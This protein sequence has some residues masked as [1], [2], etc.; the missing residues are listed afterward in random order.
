M[1]GIETLA[2]SIALLAAGGLLLSA[3]GE[4]KATDESTAEGATANARLAAEVVASEELILEL[5]PTLKK[6]APELFSEQCEFTG[7]SPETNSEVTFE[8]LAVEERIWS[9]PRRRAL[10]RPP[11]LGDLLTPPGLET[12]EIGK[13][14]IS[15][16]KGRF[17]S[18]GRTRFESV[19]GISSRHSGMARLS[20]NIAQWSRDPGTGRWQIMDWKQKSL[21]ALRAPAPFFE[22]V[23][24]R[25][26]PDAKT[27]AAARTSLHQKILVENYFGGNPARNRPGYSDSRFYPDSVNIHPALSVADVDGDG[28]EDLYVCVRW[29]K[30]L[31]LRNRGDGTFEEC[32]TRFGLDVDGRNTVALF[33]DFDNDGD[34]DLLLG[35]SLERSL[36]L[37][38]RE[39]RFAP[40]PDPVVNGALPWLVTS[41]SAADV[42]ND[43][44]LDVYLCTY[45]PLD[46]NQRISGQAV[47]SA[48]EWARRFLASEDE[49][50]VVRRQTE[51]HSYLAQV[52]PPNV[53]L[54]GRGTHFEVAPS[55]PGM[56]G[57][58][59]SFHAAWNDYDRDGDQ[60]LYVA[61]DFAPDFFYRNDGSGGFTDITAA[62][63]IDTMGFAMGAAWGDYD[64]DGYDD[65]YVSNMYS[66]AGRRITAQIPGL[67]RRFAATAGG[68]FLYRNQGDGTLERM[69]GGDGK[70]IPVHL[71]GWSWGGQFCDF[72]NDGHLDLYVSSGFYTPPP[73]LDI[74][75]DL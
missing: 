26:L 56:A 36:Y 61:N 29:G 48:P 45:S 6:F 19:I 51:A 31:L 60:D 42:N 28:L 9:T 43:G 44:F 47:K 66:K 11:S 18:P 58:R 74:G 15:L 14:E 8:D 46:I 64:G 70:P 59:N 34:P 5:T 39:G 75:V 40:H 41:A 49:A 7:L 63:G 71:A 3:C 62:A 55:S 23:L 33:A 73:G 25:V 32:A 65:L 37:V 21:R 67:D 54:L 27:L 12:E 30:N 10:S 38:N 17:F 68:N 20:M 22:E 24:E 69:S 13:A 35:R 1:I 57:Y 52:G 4:E 2:R 53:L 72:D 50:E 16:V